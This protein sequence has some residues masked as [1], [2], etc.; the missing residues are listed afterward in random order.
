MV[1]ARAR[2]RIAAMLAATLFSVAGPARP[3][4]PGPQPA[5]G[6]VPDIWVLESRGQA[7]CEI[8]LTGRRAVG[9]GFRAAVPPACQ[10]ALPAGIKGWRPTAE[11]LALVG[12]D[13]APLA[14]FERWSQSL[15]VGQGPAAFNLQLSRASLSVWP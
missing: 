4:P 9:G 13:G 2:R 5:A 10:P 8:G 14:N 6:D 3:L 1:G 11:G 15:F 7:V 12:A